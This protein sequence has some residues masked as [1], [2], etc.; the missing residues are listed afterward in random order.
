VLGIQISERIPCYID[1][2]L[3]IVLVIQK[4]LL[5]RNLSPQTEN[6]CRVDAFDESEIIHHSPHTGLYS[7]L[8]SLPAGGFWGIVSV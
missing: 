8:W 1:I 2:E 5:A 7:V 6:P 4:T 3:K